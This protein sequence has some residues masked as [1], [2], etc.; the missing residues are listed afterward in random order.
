MFKQVP[1]TNAFSSGTH[2]W[3]AES[4]NPLSSLSVQIDWHLKFLSRQSKDKSP[5]LIESSC[6]L[7]C[8]KIGF[9]CFKN[10]QEWIQEVQS[11]WKK[12]NKPSLKIFLPQKISFKDLKNEW[13]EEPLPYPIK[14]VQG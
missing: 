13:K 1:L 7:P 3:V 2:L 6:Y 14:W 10:S 5:L 8:Q 4:F 11:F 9:L 12:L